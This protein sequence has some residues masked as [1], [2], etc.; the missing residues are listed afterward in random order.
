MLARRTC[1]LAFAS[2][3]AGACASSEPIDGDTPATGG[4]A[5]ASDAAASDA[6]SGGNAGVGNSAG[7]PSGGSGG[8][9]PGGA[10]GA[11]PDGGSGASGGSC[12]AEVC[13]G[14]DDDCDG[15]ADNGGVCSTGCVGHK[16]DNHGYA[17]CVAQVTLSLAAEDC[18]NQNMKPARPN[19]AAE[20]D[21]LRS[22]ATAAGMGA[23][24]LGAT[25][26][27]TEGSW[28]WPD[29]TAFWTG[30]AN[31]SP[32]AGVYT[33]WG[34]NDPTGKDANDCMQMSTDGK[35]HETACSG[36]VAYVCEDY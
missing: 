7:F 18:I 8:G 32:V 20:N 34:S 4:S 14:V 26:W 19:D 5:G 23:I 2:A 13:N 35:W 33:N 12:G 28:E 6:A 24:W 3:L 17:Y 9:I 25:D 30:G 22:T 36:K 1:L 27:T 11:A 16:F 10:A 31:G 29:G 21:W 15:T